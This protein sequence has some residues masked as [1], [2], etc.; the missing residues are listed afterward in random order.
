VQPTDPDLVVD[1]QYGAS[2]DRLD[3][4]VALHRRF[5]TAPV[6]WQQWVFDRLQLTEAR[7]VLEV[8]AGTGELWRADRGSRPSGS[9]LV[10]TDRSEA[11]CR[12]LRS[13]PIAGAAVA[14]ADVM[15]LPFGASVFDS[16]IANHMLYHAASP[17]GA[18][19]EIAR[20]LRTGGRLYAATNSVGH[21][22]Q[23]ETLAEQV[24]LPYASMRLHRPFML[25]DAPQRLSRHFRNVDV[26]VFDAELAV[27][28][29]QPVVDYLASVADLSAEQREQLGALVDA[30]IAADGA[31]TITTRA[32]LA[33]AVK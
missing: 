18:L 27:T 9:R 10:L 23:L 3:A 19:T 22:R 16:V 21:L 12:Q 26:C 13:L 15:R 20:V 4:R 6:E 5:S 30:A 33:T 11:M 8:G 17:D 25:E 31:F 2:T 14:R 28:E 7:A 29:T 1:K 32:G 24:G